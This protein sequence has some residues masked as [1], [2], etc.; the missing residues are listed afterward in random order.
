[1]RLIK[2]HQNFNEFVDKMCCLSKYE[3]DYQMKLRARLGI[4]YIKQL[5]SLLFKELAF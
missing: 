4:E 1:M 3:F 2:Q 5:Y